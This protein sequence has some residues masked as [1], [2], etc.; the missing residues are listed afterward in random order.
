MFARAASGSLPG[1]SG[2]RR[3]VDSRQPGCTERSDHLNVSHP[4]YS[5]HG[6]FLYGRRLARLSLPASGCFESAD[7]K[8]LTRLK[9]WDFPPEAPPTPCLTSGLAGT[10]MGRRW[11]G[12]QAA[13]LAGSAGQPVSLFPPPHAASSGWCCPSRRRERP[14]GRSVCLQQQ[15]VRVSAEVSPV[16]QP[17]APHC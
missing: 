8:T 2:P 13:N 11:E 4:D 7:K 1:S 6:L 3:H 14:R 12:P 9:F 16:P 5:T 15:P 17:V 10:G